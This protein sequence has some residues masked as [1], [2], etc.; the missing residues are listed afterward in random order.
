MFSLRQ[1]WNDVFPQA[2]LYTLDVKVNCMDPGWPI[3]KT[4]TP[5]IHVNPNFFK[6]KVHIN[7]FLFVSCQFC[8]I[9]QR[10]ALV[11]VFTNLMFFFLWQAQPETDMQAQLRE[12]ERELLELKKR[13]LEL[14]LAATKKHIEE[15][16][17]QL[18]LQT[19]S[20]VP[21]SKPDYV[22]YEYMNCI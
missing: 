14:E 12:K 2:K 5:S 15:Q 17:K 20:V 7:L 16:E 4:P 13:K 1:T 8:A 18:N 10:S 3:A 19:A 21:L 11:P 9:R 6:S 22:S